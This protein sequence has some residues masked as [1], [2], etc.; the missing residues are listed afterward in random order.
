M[1]DFALAAL[2]AGAILLASTISVELGLSVALIELVV[3]VIVGNTAHVVVPNWL[4][5]IGSFAGIVLTFQAGAEVDVPQLV[6]E[7]KASVSI[8]L[9]SFFAPFAVVALVTYYGL[10]WTRTQAEIGGLALSTT[11]LA[12]VYAV[13]VETGLIRELVGKRLMSATFV[14]DIATVTGLTVL[15]LKPTLWIIPFALVSVALIFG[16]PY[17]AGRFFPRYGNRVIEPEVKLVFACLFLLMWL[18]QRVLARSRVAA[19]RGV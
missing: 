6:R 10:D 12:V 8:G 15:F 5:F 4:S 17:A 11:S 16:L 1:S 7:W 14:T 9:V 19:A 13:L 3:G 18:G 2:L